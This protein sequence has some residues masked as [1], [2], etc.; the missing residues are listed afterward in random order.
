MADQNGKWIWSL[1]QHLL[2]HSILLRIAACMGPVSD[3]TVDMVEWQSDYG[4]VFRVSKAYE[5]HDGIDVG[6]VAPIWKLIHRF[7]GPQKIKN[8]LW[9]RNAAVF[10]NP[11]YDSQSLLVRCRR[12]NDAV[13]QAIASGR[14]AGQ[15][16]PLPRSLV[17]W[18]PPLEGQY[19]LNVDVTDSLDALRLLRS[20]DDRKTTSNLLRDIYLL[21]SREWTIEFQH[22]Y[23]EGNLVADRL[24]QVTNL[25]ILDV[26]LRY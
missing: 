15:Q 2:P 7:R 19:K 14:V 10:E 6:E 4:G 22:V 12:W 23:M 16:S 11:L 5:I 18:V 3:G 26:V 1:F 9:L 20:L 25:D 8:F 17:V 21:I 13:V 24:A